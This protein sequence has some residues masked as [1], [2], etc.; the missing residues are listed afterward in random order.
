[1]GVSI[2][3]DKHLV[4]FCLFM[5]HNL[6][7]CAHYLTKLS[8]CIPRCIIDSNGGSADGPDT[9]KLCPLLVPILSQL[10]HLDDLSIDYCEELLESDERLLDTFSALKTVRTLRVTSFG[11]LTYDLVETIQ[12]PLVN[13]HVD[14]ACPAGETL[15]GG[16]HIMPNPLWMLNRHQATLEKVFIRY[17]DLRAEYVRSNPTRSV[18]PRVS[19][20]ALIE[21]CVDERSVLVDAFPNLRYLEFTGERTDAEGG[22]NPLLH[23][24]EA[25]ELNNPDL[26][27]WA[28]LD[29]VYGDLDALYAL[30]LR[31]SVTRLDVV[32]VM[33]E[34]TIIN[35]RIVIA[36]V[37]PSRLIVHCGLPGDRN[38]SAI[39]YNELTYLLHYEPDHT[40]THIGVDLGLGSLSYDPIL[41]QK[42]TVDMLKPLK[43]VRFFTFRLHAVALEYEDEHGP[44]SAAHLEILAKF[45]GKFLAFWAARLA[46]GVPT[47]EYLCFRVW[48]KEVY[49]HVSREQGTPQYTRL[50]LDAGHALVKAEGMQWHGGV[51]PA[52]LL[53]VSDDSFEVKDSADD[54][55][56]RA[57]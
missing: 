27:C 38:E 2:R 29:H 10:S 34:D 5:R 9:F 42:A 8:I 48:N 49:W 52:R 3:T 1:M 35:M 32:C 56:D 15:T 25:Y 40:I 24:D 23:I 31:C 22:N 14:G 7:G 54:P 57:D 13:V 20:L 21:C 26:R 16:S 39:F 37:L 47:L 45:H 36:D 50:G 12:S 41:Y 4:S 53:A 51:K 6:P 30:G 18:F 46:E 19:A 43:V 11:F 28:H 33:S 17:F 44:P 55:D